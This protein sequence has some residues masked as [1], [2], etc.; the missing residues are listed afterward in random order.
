MGLEGFRSDNSNSGPEYPEEAAVEKMVV[1]YFQEDFQ[2]VFGDDNHG[3]DIP[4]VIAKDGDT[5]WGVE[6]KGDAKS[7]KQ[8]I[9]SAVG[10]VIYEMGA[11]SINS[12]NIKWG[13]AF[14]E[15]IDSRKQYRDRI[16]ENISKEILDMLNIYVLFVTENGKVDVIPPG[17]IGAKS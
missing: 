5:I 6:V 15:S 16:N 13:I 11:D 2:E 7:N 4:D 8:R 10:Q 3:K 14:P 12:D 1:E 17:G 9:Y